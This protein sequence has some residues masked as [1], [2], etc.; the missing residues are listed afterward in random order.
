MNYL[1]ALV[2][3]YS[4][5]H[6]Y[7][8]LPFWILTPFRRLIRLVSKK[9]L[10]RYLSNNKCRNNPNPNGI[11]VSLTTFPARINNVWQV[12]ECM[13][14]QT[15][16]PQ[17]I[18]LWL[19]KVQFPTEA[20]I[21]LSLKSE[22]DDVFLIRFVEGDIR[23]HKKYYYVSKEYPNSLVFLIDDDIY[24]PSDIIQKSLDAFNKYPH[25]VICNYGYKIKYSNTVGM[26]PYREWEHKY[27]ATNDPNLFFGS[28][29]GTLFIPSNMYKDL[30]DVKTACR[31]C[32]LA[33]DIW[34]NAMARLSGCNIILLKN[35]NILP[36]YNRN[37]IKLMSE[38]LNNNQNDC[39]L[40]SV[41][42]YYLEKESVNPF[43]Q[44]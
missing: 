26:L 5:L 21:P 4:I 24:Y 35:G 17:K 18:I 8:W 39:Q 16:K 19:S 38:N 9:T 27:N 44:E 43:E 14:R 10:P 6:I 30:C 42:K 7:R 12:I 20:D 15:C 31:L 33:D 2:K 28:G 36:V 40:S 13:K 25:S 23:S 1:D 29:G 11:I 3:C 22:E 32:P 37:N 34:L 41:I